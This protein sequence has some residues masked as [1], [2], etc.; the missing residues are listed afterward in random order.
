[1]SPQIMVLTVSYS[2]L[3]SR[4]FLALLVLMLAVVNGLMLLWRYAT[5]RPIL[6]VKAVYPSVY[7]WFFRLPAGEY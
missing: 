1:M 6:R 3:F 4:D 7:Q 2:A 5:D